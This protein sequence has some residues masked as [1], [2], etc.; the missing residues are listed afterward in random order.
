MVTN[1]T[2]I[3]DCATLITPQNKSLVPCPIVELVP[4]SNV[5]RFAL[6]LC[7]IMSSQFSRCVMCNC[8]NIFSSI[9]T[10][11]DTASALKMTVTVSSELMSTA[12]TLALNFSDDNENVET[13][14]MSNINSFKLTPNYPFFMEQRCQYI[15]KSFEQ[16]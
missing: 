4:L 14:L 6:G 10:Y 11:D 15:Q 13:E 8:V 16:G 12:K 2:N 1:M 9:C 7:V 5:D 3:K